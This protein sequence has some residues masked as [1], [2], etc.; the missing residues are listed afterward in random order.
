M[1]CSCLG[2][3]SSYKTLGHFIFV[4]RVAVVKLSCWN[5]DA[6]E[7]SFIRIAFCHSSGFKNGPCDDH[8]H[9]RIPCQFFALSRHSYGSSF[10][11]YFTMLVLL[12]L[13]FFFRTHSY[14]YWLERVRR[15]EMAECCCRW[16]LGSGTFNLKRL[17]IK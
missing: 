9:R 12:L 1:L 11:V 5:A 13:V 8:R 10:F 16:H 15:A 17:S 4:I 3:S 7:N 6:F 14:Y 2:A